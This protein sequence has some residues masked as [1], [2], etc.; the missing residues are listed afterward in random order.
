M[1]DRLNTPF[2]NEHFAAYCLQMVG[3]PYWY[4]TC[5]YKATSS[6]L[7]RK[8]KQYPSHYQSSRTARYKQDIA[9]KKVVADCI[10]GAK[11]YAWTGGGQAMLE[12]IGTDGS[13]SNKYGSNGCPDKGAGSMFS[14]AKSKGKAWGEIN[15]IPEV[16][17]LAVHKEGH[18]GYYVGNGYVVE[19]RGFNY[20]C[21]K[22]KLLDRSWLYWYELPFIDYGDAIS[23][24]ESSPVELT[25]GCRLL[26]KNMNGADVKELQEA[27]LALG[28]TLAYGADG[29][30]G[31][32]TQKAVK[33]FQKDAGL[34]QDGKYGDQ[35]HAALMDALADDEDPQEPA[36][37]EVPEENDAPEVAPETPKPAMIVITANSG[38]VNIRAG[39]G[40]NYSR[41]TSVV[42]GTELKFV[43][44]A[45]NG[46]Y[47]VEI[48][49]RIGWVSNEFSHMVA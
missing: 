27:L 26:Q 29:K 34:T 46:W 41:I 5:G 16:V 15:T 8:T 42:A 3:Q 49:S 1:A 39:N 13:V 35:T 37:P 14:Y 20:G 23:S 31:S 4:G 19:W 7:T 33:A 18:V 30:F 24:S 10:G 21:V 43:A 28:Y 17:G 11:G 47:A 9:D 32:E 2:T 40:T 48:G 6:L 44:Q 12:A 36:E 38:K 25:L 22:T 45:V